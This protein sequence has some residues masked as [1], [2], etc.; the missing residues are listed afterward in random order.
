MPGNGQVT[1]RNGDTVTTSPESAARPKTGFFAGMDALDTRTD[2]NRIFMDLTPDWRVFAFIAALAC[3]ACLLFGLSPALK[4]TGTNPGKT[5]QAGGRSSTDSHER[6]ALRR[7]LVVVQVALSMVLIVGALLFTRSLQ[8]LVTVDLGFRQDGIIAA[9]VDLRR[10]TVDPAARLQVYAQAAERV[11]AVP[12][13][14][15]VSEA[16]LVPSHLANP[17]APSREAAGPDAPEWTVLAALQ[18]TF[19][20]LSDA[21]FDD[22]EAISW[23]LRKAFERQGH[24]VG[25]AASG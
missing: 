5:M 10:A 13:V 19:T 4:A 6:F 9:S 12:G 15:H 14:L 20:L 11:R 8:N 3:L 16:F 7:A 24:T 17:S 21:G 2:S 23:A 18:G 1:V 22:E 25:V